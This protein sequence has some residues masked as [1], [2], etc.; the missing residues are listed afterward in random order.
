[1][2]GATNTNSNFKQE[3]RHQ[4]LNEQQQNHLLMCEIVILL[5]VLKAN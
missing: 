5:S 3:Q 2:S 1:M 4:T